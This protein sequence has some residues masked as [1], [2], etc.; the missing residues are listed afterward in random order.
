MGMNKQQD[1]GYHDS[2]MQLLLDLGAIKLDETGAGYYDTGKFA[3][4]E[5]IYA[6]ADAETKK[7]LDDK[8]LYEYV[9]KLFKEAKYKDEKGT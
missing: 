8:T 6:N 2:A 4:I 3:S 5:E 9:D 7:Q 1:L